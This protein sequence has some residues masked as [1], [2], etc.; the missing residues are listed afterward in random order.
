MSFPRARIQRFNEFPND[1]PPPGAYDPKF[2]NKIK[3]L[4]IEK[5]DRFQDNKSISSSCADCNTST[6]SK[7]GSITGVPPFKI[8]QL[9]KKKSVTKPAQNNSSVKLA[10]NKKCDIKYDVTKELADLKV[11]CHNKDKTIQ[12]Y[13]KQIEDMKE[14]IV[15]LERQ[16]AAIKEEQTE[17]ESRYKKNMDEMVQDRQLADI[18]MKAKMQKIHEDFQAEISK[19]KDEEYKLRIELTNLSEVREDLDVKLQQRHDLVIQLQSQLSMLECERDEYK[20]ENENLAS[21]SDRHA[22]SLAA[23]YGAEMDGLIKDFEQRKEKLT[24]EL[25]SERNEKSQLKDS[26]QIEIAAKKSLEE[27]LLKIEC[28]YSDV[29]SRLKEAK[30]ELQEVKDHHSQVLKNHSQ[31][32][33]TLMSRHAEEVARLAERTEEFRQKCA[34]LREKRHEMEKKAESMIQEVKQSVNEE[35]Q[36]ATEKY[37]TTLAEM[38]SQLTTA[39]KNLEQKEEEIVQLLVEIEELKESSATKESS[40]QSLQTDLDRAEAELADRKEEIKTLKDQLRNEASEMVTRRRRLDLVMSENQAT[41]TAISERLAESDSEVERLQAELEWEKTRLREHRELLNTMR[42]NSTLAHEQMRSLLQQLDAKKEDIDQL[43]VDNVVKFDAMKSLFDAKIQELNDVTAV[44]IT[45]LRAECDK[46]NDENKELKQ[47]LAEMLE[48]LNDARELLLKAEEQYDAQGIELAQ[49]EVS[50]HKFEKLYKE[51]NKKYEESNAKLAE[52]Q[53]AIDKAQSYIAEWTKKFEIME[54]KGEHCKENCST[55]EHES[56]PK[57]KTEVETKVELGTSWNPEAD[58][59]KFFEDRDLLESNL[60]K[61]EA[62]Y[63]DLADKYA[64]VIGHNNHKQKIQH[65]LQMKKEKLQLKE[66]VDAARRIIAQQQRTIEKLRSDERARQH[67]K[68]NVPSSVVAS[69]HKPSTPLK[70]RNV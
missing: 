43:V 28:L 30:D 12:E 63:K 17:I 67:S 24:D 18:E 4:V 46:S 11:E 64:A 14:D 20:A 29:K 40:N 68:E 2:K 50:C 31:E 5:T 56:D 54:G 51:S 48:K 15:N 49:L 19:M 7:S 59:S 53:L 26:L 60:R 10:S 66:D 36:K 58:F 57:D 25:E 6:S 32:I 38:D 35:L 44:E 62:E 37:I 34:V 21:E 39:Q 27:K 69:P 70:D 13:E 3:G 1:A 55:P 41:V 33:Q 9:P 8:P 23:S 45:R 52:Q 22:M 61:V 65:M 42:A 16:L 47:Q